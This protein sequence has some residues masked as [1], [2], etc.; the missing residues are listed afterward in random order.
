MLEIGNGPLSDNVLQG[1]PLSTIKR[2]FLLTIIIEMYPLIGAI[3][4]KNVEFV[5]LKSNIDS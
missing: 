3:P 1:Y 5:I 4:P 2:Q